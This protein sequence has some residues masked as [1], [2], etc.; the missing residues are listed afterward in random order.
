LSEDRASGLRIDKLSA[1]YLSVASAV[2]V[3][4]P[5]HEAPAMFKLNGRYYLFGS[6]LTGWNTNNN[7]YTTATSLAGPWSSWSVFASP[8]SNTFNSQTTFILPVAGTAGTTFMY[9]GDRWTPTS[10]GTSPYIWLPLQV[11]GANVTMSWHTTWSIDS[12][13]GLWGDAGSTS[14][15][16]SSVKSSLLLDVTGSSKTAGA[17]IIQWNNN[18]GANQ[19]WTLVSASGGYFFIVNKNS[20][21]YLDVSSSSTSSGANIVQ[22]TSSGGTSQQWSL[23]AVSGGYYTIVNRNSGLVLD[24]SGGSI[25]AGANIIQWT[26]NGGTN[27]QWLVNSL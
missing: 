20:G 15:H 21:L 9:M 11:N 14:Y 2:V 13:T 7:Q 3:L 24:V 18:G 6:L 5:N 26:S 12:A 25:T 22:W 16:I 23:V 8:G 27:Q 1:N 4:T 19:D 17:Q 10:L